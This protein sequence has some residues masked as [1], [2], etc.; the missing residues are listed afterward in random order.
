MRT[1]AGLGLIRTASKLYSSIILAIM[2][3]PAVTNLVVSLGKLS[4]FPS[5]RSNHSNPFNF[6]LRVL[7]Y[8]SFPLVLTFALCVYMLLVDMDDV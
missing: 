8:D 6:F 2:N 3:N 7:T 1:F 4:S 5:E